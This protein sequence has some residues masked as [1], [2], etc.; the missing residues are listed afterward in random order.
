M[1][2]ELNLVV[3]NGKLTSRWSGNLEVFGLKIKVKEYEVS[4]DLN[5]IMTQVSDL[6]E[7][8]EEAAGWTVVQ[9]ITKMIGIRPAIVERFW[10]L[11]TK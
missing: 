5:E 1:K 4:G 8:D 2:Y 6:I 11:L 10:G 9:G 7:G 3:E